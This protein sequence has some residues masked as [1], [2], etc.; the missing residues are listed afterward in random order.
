MCSGTAL[1]ISKKTTEAGVLVLNVESKPPP[2][3]KLIV[4]G[5]C[6][7]KIFLI[8]LVPEV[9]LHT[10]AFLPGLAKTVSTAAPYSA[11]VAKSQ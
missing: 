7:K 8:H 5:F 3:L 9:Q 10:R 4:H 11:D 1:S 6:Q 2:P